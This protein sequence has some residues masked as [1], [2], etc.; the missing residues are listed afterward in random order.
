VSTKYWRRQNVGV[1]K[2]LASTKYQRQQN[3]GSNKISASSK[4]RRQQII[5]VDKI[6]AS[7]TVLSKIKIH[8]FH[9]VLCKTCIVCREVVG[10]TARRQLLVSGE[11]E[12]VAPFFLGCAE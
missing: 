6:L 10:L 12:Q 1:D 9:L 7:I 4:Y 2:I 11:G 3:I 5:G 8:N